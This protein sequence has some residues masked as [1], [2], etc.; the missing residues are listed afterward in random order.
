MMTRKPGFFIFAFIL[1]LAMSGCGKEGDLSPAG[2]GGP[3]IDDTPGG[4][5]PSTKISRI[6]ITPGA[7]LLTEPGKSVQLSAQAYDAEGSPI[8]AAITW[9]TS[10]EAAVTITAE[11][12]AT[13]VGAVGSAQ[14]T[15]QAEGVSSGPVLALLAQPVPGAI[16]VQDSH[17]IG[18][19]EAVDPAAPYGVGWRYRVTL[20]GINLPNPG[21]ILV[22]TGEVPLGGRVVEAAQNGESV[23]VTLEVVSLSQIFADLRVEE[24]LD[25]SRADFEVSDEIAARYDVRREPDGRITFTPRP[26]AAPVQPKGFLPEGK[27]RAPSAAVGTS[28][29]GPFSCDDS[30]VTDLLGLEVEPVFALSADLNV[31]ISYDSAAGGFQKLLLTGEP[32]AEATFKP[33]IK[34][35]LGGE[36][37]CKVTLTQIPVPVGGPLAMIFGAK[38]P[39]GVG[40]K[41]AGEVSAPLI[42]F[43]VQ[44][45]ATAAYTV[46]VQCAVTCGI[47]A[48]MEN[49]N[50]KKPPKWT[51]PNTALDQLNMTLGVHAYAFA[52]VDIGNPFLNFL[53]FEALKAKFGI[54]HDL[55]LKPM[56]AQATDAAGASSFG[57]SLEAS[58]GA[59]EGVDVIKD[60]LEIEFLTLELTWDQALAHSPQGSLTITPASVKAGDDTQLGEMAIFTV[61]LDSSTFLGIE[62]VEGVEIKWLKNGSLEPGRPGCTSLAAIPGQTVFTCQTDFLQEHLGEQTFY[63]FVK[64]SLLGVPL[65]IPLEVADNAAAKVT[66][67]GQPNVRVSR[68][69]SLGGD[70]GNGQLCEVIR[71]TSLAPFSF[72]GSL[73]DCPWA[74]VSQDSSFSFDTGGDLLK[75]TATG[76]ASASESPG[77]VVNYFTVHFDVLEPV[78]VSIVASLTAQGGAGSSISQINLMSPVGDS[79]ICVAFIGGDVCPASIDTLVDLN[80][81]RYVLEAQVWDSKSGIAV[82]SQTFNLTMDFSPT[83]P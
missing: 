67:D 33:Q 76:T 50:E 51:W 39:I 2:A 17:V 45:K 38:V 28:A 62:A 63:A 48:E 24:S 19:P 58:A 21:D 79:I 3:P 42:S 34:A 7:F 64:A 25:L 16:L 47:V 15:A 53:Q 23:T 18:V 60:L 22:G 80:P 5:L 54:K 77:L 43:E 13:A 70:K 75:V 41:I 81:G 12:L 57:L 46:G 6:K 82:K 9:K 44:G 1:L 55:K 71:H 56:L 27:S 73:P 78:S 26:E 30:E 61:T 29:L 83:G 69:S 10:D 74:H 4:D 20:S 52:T 66:V 11:G 37:S 35:A 72:S 8:D 14:I 40:F 59:G 32:T 68:T 65:P 31:E 49:K 36:I